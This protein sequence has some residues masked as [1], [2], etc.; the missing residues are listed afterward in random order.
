LIA[1]PA[2][3]VDRASS[4]VST[5]ENAYIPAAISATEIPARLGASAGPVIDTRPTSAWIN[6]S[7]AFFAANGPSGP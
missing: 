6:M 4:A 3:L 2:P 7:Y 1:L 5:P